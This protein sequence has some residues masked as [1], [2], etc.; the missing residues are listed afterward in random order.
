M[1]AWWGNSVTG[2]EKTYAEMEYQQGVIIE[3][4]NSIGA[5][6]KET[7]QCETY[8]RDRTKYK[9]P[10]GATDPDTARQGHIDLGCGYSGNFDIKCQKLDVLGNPSYLGQCTLTVDISTCFPPTYQEALDSCY[11]LPATTTFVPLTSPTVP[12]WLKVDELPFELAP[13]PKSYNMTAPAITPAPC[14]EVNVASLCEKDRGFPKYGTGADGRWDPHLSYTRAVPYFPVVPCGDQPVSIPR[15]CP[16][17]AVNMIENQTHP[18]FPQ[19]NSICNLN[20]ARAELAHVCHQNQTSARE[21]LE[22]TALNAKIQNMKD[23]HAALQSWSV[24]RTPKV[25]E[26]VEVIDCI[27]D[28]LPR[29]YNGIGEPKFSGGFDKL[30]LHNQCRLHSCKRNQCLK[31]KTPCPITQMTTPP[32]R[33]C[34]SGQD[35]TKYEC[36]DKVQIMWNNPL[37]LGFGISWAGIA[38]FMFCGAIASFVITKRREGD[39]G[40]RFGNGEDQEIGNDPTLLA[41][42]GGPGSPQGPRDAGDA[43]QMQ[44]YS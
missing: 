4:G 10:R 21:Q 15:P 26:A 33:Q 20:K 30:R 34:D 9:G 18:N 7:H 11:H 42:R 43:W 14:C 32:E 38:L 41:G 24:G 39:E 2:G 31:I 44:K 25:T 17:I 1:K 6:L 40:V 35:D 16:R 36:V 23:H 27:D 12:D 29:R 8:F 37:S 5:N 28:N 22:Q 19:C 13:L 3:T